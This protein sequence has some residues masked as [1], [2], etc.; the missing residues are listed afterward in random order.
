MPTQAVPGG[1]WFFVVKGGPV[2][3]PIIILSIV[4]LTIILAKYWELWRFRLRLNNLTN[5]LCD[6]VQ[7]GN[8]SGAL[9]ASREDATSLSPFIHLPFSSIWRLLGKSRM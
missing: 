7:D 6:L 5:K 9:Q 8:V 4:A 3:I 2:M 1:L